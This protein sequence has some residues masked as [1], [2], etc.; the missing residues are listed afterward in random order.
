MK[1]PSLVGTGDAN[2][3]ATPVPDLDDR[4]TNGCPVIVDGDVN[5]CTDSGVVAPKIFFGRAVQG[6]TLIGGRVGAEVH[7]TPRQIDPFWVVNDAVGGWQPNDF[8]V[9]EEPMI[10]R[11]R[12]GGWRGA[13]YFKP[14]F[15]A[16][17]L[18]QD[19]DKRSGKRLACRQG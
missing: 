13:A 2:V 14:N 19:A 3:S 10:W 1:K 9:D 12:L 16:F 15:L 7:N 4:S 6:D 17:D 8:A 5:T 18:D 11:M